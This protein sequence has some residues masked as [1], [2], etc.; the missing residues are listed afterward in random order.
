MAPERPIALTDK[1]W[2]SP[3]QV[4]AS[5]G[6]NVMLL[7]ILTGRYYQLDEISSDIWQRLE[8]PIRVADLC[9]ELKTAYSGDAQEVEQ[10]IIELLGKLE[11]EQLIQRGS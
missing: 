6:E 9:S 7:S 8:H 11:E 5:L 2:W 4:G 1:V 10:D 3:D